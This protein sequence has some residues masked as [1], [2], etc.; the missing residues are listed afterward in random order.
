MRTE[1][2]ACELC[3]EETSWLK[4]VPGALKA[5]RRCYRSAYKVR[6]MND[7]RGAKAEALAEGAPV[8]I[9][10]NGEVWARCPGCEKK[11]KRKSTNDLHCKR[12]ECREARRRSEDS[13][14][15]PISEPPDTT[16]NKAAR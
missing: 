5:C 12:R 2:I 7:L 6:L 9:W 16:M 14:D 10:D 1:K 11:F 13:Y 15:P 4:D 8:S 3:G